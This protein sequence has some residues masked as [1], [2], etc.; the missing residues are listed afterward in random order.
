MFG[1][2]KNSLECIFYYLF[3]A[4]LG[5]NHLGQIICARGKFLG[6]EEEKN[7]INKEE[8]IRCEIDFKIIFKDGCL[9]S[10]FSLI[11]VGSR[12]FV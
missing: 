5:Q 10:N 3:F 1:L 6:V 4:R 9:K 12:L 7:N 11:D 2:S 8:K